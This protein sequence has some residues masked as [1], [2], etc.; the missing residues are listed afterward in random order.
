MFD[1][2]KN[3][4]I[5][6]IAILISIIVLQVYFSRVTQSELIQSQETS[7]HS[8]ENVAL[9]HELERDIIDLQRHL[10]IHKETA[11]TSAITRFYEL[12]MRVKE[13]LS[14]FENDSNIVFIESLELGLMSSMRK[15]L[16]NYEENF[17]N[18]INWRSQRKVIF[19]DN[20]Q[21][22][23]KLLDQLIIQY[24]SEGNTQN[25]A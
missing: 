12:M 21:L 5:V 23:F 6:V 8:Y 9:V 17:T 20:I 14:L 11:S 1:S 4:I 18:V 24:E 3:Q 22:N 10:L 16:D 25:N 2:L 7:N 19:N 13:K 15:H